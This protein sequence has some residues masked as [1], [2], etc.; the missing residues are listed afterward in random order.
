MKSKLTK[1]GYEL[2]DVAIVQAEISDIDSRGDVNPK[3]EIL[4][5]YDEKLPVFVA[6][7]ATVIDRENWQYFTP[8][9]TPV[10]PRSAY[11][12]SI[13]DFQT[14]VSVARYAFVSFS[15]KEAERMT[16]NNIKN[17]TEECR[18]LYSC[19]TQHQCSKVHICIDIAQG[20]MRKMFNVCKELKKQLGDHIVIMAGNIANPNAYKHYCEYGIDWVRVSVGTGSRCTTSCTTGVHYPMASLLDEINT[21]RKKMERKNK[22]R[23]KFLLKPKH[24]TRVIADGGINS[25]DDITK[26]L[27][28][29]ADAVM[30]GKMFN[31]CKE[32]AYEPKYAL[33]EEEFM[34]GNVRNSQNKENTLKLYREY[35]GMGSEKAKRIMG[36]DSN[37][38]AEGI[39]RPTEVKYSVGELAEKIKSFICSCM[40]Y[41]NSR[42]LYEL[43]NNASVV[44]LGSGDSQYRK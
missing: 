5:K 42:N 17:L 9:F 3:T 38:A 14:R 10:I 15:L 12:D 24:I 31:E 39:S 30:C 37:F 1:I 33:N 44:I 28:L 22:T 34:K 40:S 2:R 4:N 6:P 43:R 41:T 20:T 11:S 29:G 7:M 23:Q 35:F 8:Y 16:H 19:A 21:I 26:S 25:F 36:S 32:A 13:E 18:I 27:V